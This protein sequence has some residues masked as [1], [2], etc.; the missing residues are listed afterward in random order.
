MEH[1][2][3][4]V[5]A[6]YEYDRKESFDYNTKLEVEMR[7]RHEDNKRQRLRYEAQYEEVLHEIKKDYKDTKVKEPYLLKQNIEDIFP[8]MCN[9]CNTYKV[10]P[11]QFLTKQNR[12]HGRGNCSQ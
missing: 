9:K 6:D 7:R 10:F 3:S 11:Y 8:L 1:P 5:L 4:D 2:T 12:D